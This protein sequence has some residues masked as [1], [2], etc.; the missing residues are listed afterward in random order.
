MDLEELRAVQTRERATDGLQELRDSFYAD[1]ATYIQELREER[2]RV[3][4][5]ADEPFRN[6]TV[7]ELTDEI[8]VAEQVAEAIYERR[9]GKLVKQASLAA[10]G[11]PDDQTGLTN[12]ER[13]LYTDLVD[14]IKENKQGVLDVIAGDAPIEAE[15]G[16]ADTEPG[17]ND[18]SDAAS[19]HPADDPPESPADPS[20][21]GTGAP[22]AEAMGGG[23]DAETNSADE[24]DVGE[25]A[26]Q[27]DSAA[28]DVETTTV[29]VTS[30]VG[31]IFGVDE[32]EYSLYEDD[33][34]Q[35][36]TENAEPLLERDAAEKLE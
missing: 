31:E 35:L 15:R 27:S 18:E 24:T 36:P 6:D 14:R 33:V 32:R 3:A 4:A 1:V 29:R 17:S 23:P 34:V 5:E 28:D 20:Q 26:T 11:M 19:T 22:A 30:D 7:N 8:E 13:D 9:I 10:A 2:D 16:A 12:E 21:N 25:A